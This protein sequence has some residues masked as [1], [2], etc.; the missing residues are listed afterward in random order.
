MQHNITKL[1]ADSLRTFTLTNYGIKLKSSHAYELVAAFFGYQSRAALLADTKFSIS[2][3]R[4]AEF[5]LTTPSGNFVDLRYK[6]LQDLSPGLPPSYILAEGFYSA[7]FAE[8]WIIEKVWPTFRDLANYLA[9][10]RLHQRFKMWGIDPQAITLDMDVEIEHKEDEVL[11]TVDAGSDTSV[12]ERLKD[13]VY[14]ITL[15]RIAA[16]LGYG[17][18][19]VHETRYSGE[20][21]RER[22]AAGAT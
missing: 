4:Q 20:A 1:C 12:G 14:I 15:P 2:N 10:K 5:I 18:P 21:R 16:N 6:N 17:K 7:L 19:K 11:L 9:E 22:S 13:S 8:E 3:L